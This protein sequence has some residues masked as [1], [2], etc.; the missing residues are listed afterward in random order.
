ML[1]LKLFFSLFTLI[2]YINR[3]AVLCYTAA[4]NMLSSTSRPKFAFSNVMPCTVEMSSKSKTSK[5]SSKKI[6]VSGS[7]LTERDITHG[8]YVDLPMKERVSNFAL[9]QKQAHV[10]FEGLV[11]SGGLLFYKFRNAQNPLIA[12]QLGFNIRTD[13]ICESAIGNDTVPLG[14]I[15]F[16]SII[17]PDMSKLTY[18]NYVIRWVDLIDNI[19]REV[20]G[21]S[22]A[23]ARAG[24][25]VSMLD[26]EVRRLNSKTFVD[27]RAIEFVYNG[28]SFNPDAVLTEI[29]TQRIQAVIGW[30]DHFL[31]AV[32]SSA[33]KFFYDL[34]AV[35]LVEEKVRSAVAGR[36]GPLVES[37]CSS[38][39]GEEEEEIPVDRS[40]SARNRVPHPPVTPRHGV[41]STPREGDSVA[42]GYIPDH[43]TRES[44]GPAPPRELND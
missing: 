26:A 41:P 34:E 12:G 18:K 4:T 1:L 8:W 30:T 7:E 11:Q 2:V 15:I 20:N 21:N 33:E 31:E 23:K 3:Q 39:S 43:T 22:V 36:V 44:E 40:I 27:I 5:A 38:S 32:V 42:T 29:Q 24:Q 28:D 13:S 19:S 16:S 9:S 37:D 25:L 6:V 14:P 17:L 35:V 10:Q